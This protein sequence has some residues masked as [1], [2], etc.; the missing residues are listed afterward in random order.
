MI[1]ISVT[2]FEKLQEAMI[3]LDEV[4]ILLQVKQGY[5][6]WD[7][8]A[9]KIKLLI[10]KMTRNGL[11]DDEGDITVKGAELLE[12]LCLPGEELVLSK[13]Q[14]SDSAFEAWWKEFP[15][16]DGFELNGKVF[17][18]TRSFRIKKPECK[19]KFHRIISS[20]EYTADQLINA[21]KAEVQAKKEASITG[22]DN[23]LSYLSATLAYLNGGKYEGFIDAV[24]PEKKVVKQQQKF[25]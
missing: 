13:R 6:P 19:A 16:N 20:G 15:A 23:K 17:K 3:S 25:I 21:I 9:K 12:M 10:T 8:K 11:L 7:F 24:I 2:A 4:F 5:D 18:P 22:K 14:N 1:N